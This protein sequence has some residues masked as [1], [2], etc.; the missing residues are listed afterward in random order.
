MP[1]NAKFIKNS[2][3]NNYICNICSDNIE[4]NKIIGLGCNPLK[5]IF[6]Y[7]CIND[8]YMELKKK[9]HHG[10]YTILNMCPICRKNG[11]LLPSISTIPFV[12]NLHYISNDVNIDTDTD[13][14]KICGYKLCSK[15]G[16]CNLKGNKLYGG[17]CGKHKLKKP[18]IIED[19]DI[20]INELL[21]NALNEIEIPSVDINP[22]KLSHECGVKLKTKDGYCKSKGCKSFNGY[23][24][25]HNNIMKK[26]KI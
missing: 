14:D 6:C 26:N 17:L 11:G 7:D 22:H 12:K 23:C 25:M 16:I 15:N 10:N 18:E 3:N 24:G 4:S 9:K 2:L 13:T 19:I 8:W 1:K 21:T 20:D 5:H